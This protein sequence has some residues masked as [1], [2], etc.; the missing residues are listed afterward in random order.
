MSL[1]F[2]GSVSTGLICTP[3]GRG[4]N[5]RAHSYNVLEGHLIC[6]VCKSGVSLTSWPSHRRPK[7]SSADWRR[8]PSAFSVPPSGVALT[9]LLLQTLN[10]RVVIVKKIT[11]AAR[12]EPG[13]HAF[14]CSVAFATPPRTVHLHQLPW[15]WTFVQFE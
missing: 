14:K 15:H 3:S 1:L 5:L 13:V 10:L 11:L 7:S 9:A 6:S 12:S 8:S 4:A 2:F